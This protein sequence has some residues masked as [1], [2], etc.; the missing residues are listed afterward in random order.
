M[1][2]PIVRQLILKDLYLLRWMIIGSIGA[3]AAAIAI[4]PLSPDL[5]LRRVPSRLSA[6]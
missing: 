3:G 6:R 5:R 2:A 4:M 1:S